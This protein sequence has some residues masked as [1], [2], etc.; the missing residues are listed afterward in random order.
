MS[1]SI[2]RMRDPGGKFH[3]IK[4]VH[5][6]EEGWCGEDCLVQNGH[7]RSEEGHVGLS[8]PGYVE[9]REKGGDGCVVTYERKGGG[10]GGGFSDIREKGGRGLETGACYEWHQLDPSK[11]YRK[12]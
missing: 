3:S 6:K 1:D 11:R 2:L 12:Q 8:K 7:M 5:R 9:I 4:E 10:G